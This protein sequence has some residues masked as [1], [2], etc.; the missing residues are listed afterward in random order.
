MNLS[1]GVREVE[2]T[3]DEVNA[4]P[5]AEKRR[6]KSAANKKYNQRALKRAKEALE[7]ERHARKTWNPRHEVPITPKIGL[8]FPGRLN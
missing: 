6:K 4:S 7:A 8:Q 2:D 1:D 5:R 3:V